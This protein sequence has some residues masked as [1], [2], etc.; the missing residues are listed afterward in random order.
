MEKRKPIYMIHKHH[1]THL[2]YDLRLEMDGKLKSWALRELPLHPSKPVLAIQVPDH[3]FWYR[4]FEGVIPEGSYGAGPV[5]V[6]DKGLYSGYMKDSSGK[7]ISL[8][9]GL[10]Q[11]FLL[12]FIEGKK[13]KGSFALIRISKKQRWLLLKLEDKY[14]IKDRKPAN[15]NYSVK[16]GKTI[17]QIFK[18]KNK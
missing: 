7:D 16:S 18:L 6:W 14:V 1:A 13:L 11:G 9:E 15:W 4:H 8:D 10:K 3:P 5:I 2:H 12:L 17:E